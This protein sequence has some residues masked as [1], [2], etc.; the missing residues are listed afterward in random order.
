MNSNQKLIKYLKN[1]GILETSEIISAFEEVDRADFVKLQ[2][3]AY[4]YENAPIGIG[5]GQTISQPLTVA[6]MLEKLKPKNGDEIL[7]VG[8]GSGWTTALLAHIVGKKGKVIGLELVPKLV[9][10]GRANLQKYNFSQAHIEQ[11]KKGLLGDPKQRF[12]KILVSAS[13]KRLPKELVSQLKPNGILV[14]PI[15]TSVF[16]ISKDS[17]ENSDIEEFPGFVFVPLL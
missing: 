16:R 7:D 6:F 8:S 13:A 11:A 17:H 9:D 2:D 1:T 15:G 12:N 4:A 5:H 10:F 14:L 3:K